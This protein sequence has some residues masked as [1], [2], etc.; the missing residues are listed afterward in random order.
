VPNDWDI[1]MT[2][3]PTTDLIGEFLAEHSGKQ[4]HIK[5]VADRFNLFTHG[6]ALPH[7]CVRLASRW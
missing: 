1:D 7:E 4:V 5:E 6:A 2:R 3:V